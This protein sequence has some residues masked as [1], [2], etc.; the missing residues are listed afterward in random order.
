MLKD[1]LQTAT[2]QGTPWKP[3]TRS[4][5]MDY[6][7]TTHSTTGVSPSQ[8]FHGRQM[9]TKLQIMDVAPPPVD[10]GGVRER[11]KDKQ[12]ESK[13]HT[14]MKRS[15]KHM[16]PTRTNHGKSRKESTTKDDCGKEK[17]L[18]IPAG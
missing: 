2:I 3:F 11:V 7:A 9:R 13:Q 6:R 17:P 4:F 5:L 10:E 16:F 14:D 18:H 15:A 12:D 1:C 8:L